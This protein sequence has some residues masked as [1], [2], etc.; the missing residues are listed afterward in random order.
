MVLQGGGCS[1]TAGSVP[2]ACRRP[3]AD[4]PAVA[5]ACT[6]RD[7]V[8]STRGLPTLDAREPRHVPAAGVACM[9]APPAPPAP[10]AVRYPYPIRPISYCS[11]VSPPLVSSCVHNANADGSDSLSRLLLVVLMV[12]ST[13]AAR[14]Q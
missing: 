8:V 4:D 1:A 6:V 9:C 5:S 11:V 10:P 14:L 2:V 7:P 3:W 13:W 12:R